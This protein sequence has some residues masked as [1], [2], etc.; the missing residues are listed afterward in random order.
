MKNILKYHRP[1]IRHVSLIYIFHFHGILKQL[2][3]NTHFSINLHLY[4]YMHCKTSI[5]VFLEYTGQTPKVFVL[6]YDTIS[7]G[8][9]LDLPSVTSKQPIENME[10]VQR[11]NLIRLLSTQ[12]KININ[13]HKNSIYIYKMNGDW[14]A[15]FSKTHH[16]RNTILQRNRVVLLIYC[17]KL[18]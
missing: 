9:F 8:A 13:N 15:L 4:K 1:L 10:Q 17:Q 11:F 6:I 2:I 3:L 16:V 5:Y 7:K 12:I 18:L 14:K